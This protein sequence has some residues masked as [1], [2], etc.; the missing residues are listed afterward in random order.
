MELETRGGNIKTLMIPNKLQK[1]INQL[2]C[3]IIYLE[4]ALR[5][6]QSSLTKDGFPKKGRDRPRLS[7]FTLNAELETGIKLVKK[8]CN[9]YTKKAKEQNE[10]RI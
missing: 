10:E 8:I 1:L 6:I 5:H 9:K 2:D 7:T 4:S 3:E